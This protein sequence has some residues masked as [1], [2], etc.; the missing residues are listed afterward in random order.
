[1]SKRMRITVEDTNGNVLADHIKVMRAFKPGAIS[2]VHT[3][4]MNTYMR[5]YRDWHRINI[6]PIEVTL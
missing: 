3:L 5:R 4:W 6:S 2:R 1:M